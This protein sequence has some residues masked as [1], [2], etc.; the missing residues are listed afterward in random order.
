M[1]DALDQL[2]QD[3]ARRIAG[4]LARQ[5]PPQPPSGQEDRSPWL[6]I[7]NASQ[8]LDWPKQRLYKLTAAG[9]IP[10]YKHDGRLLFHRSELD[11]W[12]R[13]HAQPWK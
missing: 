3:L 12:L 6:N 8:Y 1:S 7:A 9:A 2:L 4:E 11:T 5:A 10:H 13:E